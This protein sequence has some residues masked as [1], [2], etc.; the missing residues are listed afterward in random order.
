MTEFATIGPL[1]FHEAEVSTSDVEPTVHADA[2]TISGVICR[3][4]VISECHI[5][6]QDL[7]FVRNTVTISVN[8]C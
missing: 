6:D 1:R 7:L 3:T 5:A 2:E 8:E 4:F